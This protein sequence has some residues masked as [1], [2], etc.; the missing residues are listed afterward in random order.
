MDKEIKRLLTLSSIPGFNLLPKEEAKLAEWKKLQKR[1]KAPE[2]I[3][4]VI[5]EGYVELEGIGADGKNTFIPAQ[6]T[7]EQ[8]KKK[9]TTRK[10]TRRKNANVVKSSEKETGEL[11]NNLI[12]ES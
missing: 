6:E 8:P 10:Y 11:E 12:E 4:R 9:K 5:P 2:K 3:E 7:I 1:V